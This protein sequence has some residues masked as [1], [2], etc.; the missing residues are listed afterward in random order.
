MAA[1]MSVVITTV[2]NE[3]DAEA[4]GGKLLG[5]NLAA[6]IQEVAVKSRY[7]WKGEVQCEPEVLMLVKTATE[8]VADAMAVIHT[9]HP[10][11]LPEIIVL[12]V[13]SG[14][15]EYLAWVAAETRAL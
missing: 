13:G 4:L 8:R 11:D 6:C 2:A 1:K 10:Y 14:I 7:R 15:P 5:A 12:P 3:R 9:E